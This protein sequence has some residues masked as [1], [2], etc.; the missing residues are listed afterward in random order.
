MSEYRSEVW[1]TQWEL[2]SQ[3]MVG[4]PGSFTIAPY[5]VPQ[6]SKK[7]QIWHKAGSMG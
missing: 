2:R 7:V 1:D 3:I 4:Q 5:E 6:K